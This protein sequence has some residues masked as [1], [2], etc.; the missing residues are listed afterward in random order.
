LSLFKSRIL[1][2]NDVQSAFA[3]HNLALGTSLLY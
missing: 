3:T 2:I 1:F